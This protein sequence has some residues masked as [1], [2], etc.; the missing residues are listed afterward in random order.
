MPVHNADI[1]AIFEEI[2]DLLEI[3]A[4]NPFRIRAYRKAARILNELPQDIRILLKQNFSL[5]QLPGVGDDLAAKIVEIVE[6]GSCGLLRRLHKK[7]PHG[8]TEQLH[9]PRRCAKHGQ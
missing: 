8:I 4:A 9:I 6:S 5:T 1:S 3:E 2:A 7:I